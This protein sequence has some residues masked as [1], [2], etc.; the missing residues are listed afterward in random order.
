M[1]RER[2]GGREIENIEYSSGSD[3][4]GRGGEEERGD[5]WY[6]CPCPIRERFK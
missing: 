2:R 5:S 6:V 3:E 1:I 4:E